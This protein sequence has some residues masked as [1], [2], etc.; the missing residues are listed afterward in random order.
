[1]MRWI[2][3]DAGYI[4]KVSR[5]GLEDNGTHIC[6][7]SY[8]WHKYVCIVAVAYLNKFKYKSDFKTRCALASSVFQVTS[9]LM[10]PHMGASFL[11]V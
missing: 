7:K 2:P 9:R 8:D 5:S 3:K 1:M 4:S 10:V 6:L 11:F